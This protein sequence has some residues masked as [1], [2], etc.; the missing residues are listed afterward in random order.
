[1]KKLFS[2][3]CALSMILVCEGQKVKTERPDAEIQK[4]VLKNEKRFVGILPPDVKTV[5]FIA[6]GSYPGAK[7]HKRGIELLKN[8]GYKVKVMPNAFVRQE[9]VAQAPLEGRLSDFYAAWNDP[10]V[11]MILCVRGGRGS[12]QV[13]DNIDWSKLKDRPELY[14]Q[15]YSDITLITG[16]LLAKGKGHPISGFMSGSL[17]G[18]S[19]DSIAAAKKINHGQQLG[20]IK[21]TAMVGGDCK[22]LPLA[23]LIA[24][25]S[26]LS[27]KNYCPDTKGRIIFLEAVSTSAEQIKKDLYNL[28]EKKFFA[29]AAGVVFCQF[30]RCRNAEKIPAIL[31]EIAPKLGVPVYKGFHYGHSARLYSIDFFRPVEIKDGKLTFPAVK[32]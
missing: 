20:P 25:L 1:M 31:E 14:V 17:P 27:S 4:E 29:N 8:A 9:K 5:A 26:T 19:S 30:K 10:E 12:E 16:A 22:G 15:G 13:M 18:L 32:K 3:M 2:L 24:R 23:G 6:P 21:L 28:M 11:D 7:A